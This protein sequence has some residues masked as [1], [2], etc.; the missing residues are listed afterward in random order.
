MPS[1]P[2]TVKGYLFY[3][4]EWNDVSNKMRQTASINI[5]RGADS[6]QG[7]NSPTKAT[8]VMDN[9]DGDFSPRNPE[10]PLYGKIGRNTPMRIAVE[11]GPPYANIPGTGLFQESA[12][13]ALDQ[14]EM[15]FLLDADIRV[16]LSAREWAAYDI[17]AGIALATRWS[18]DAP[19]NLCWFL[20]RHR[21]GHLY[22]AWTENG[23]TIGSGGSHK[24]TVTVPFFNGE[25][26]AIR[27]T[28]DTDNGLGGYTLRFFY[29]NQIDGEWVELGDAI[30]NTS[31]GSTFIHNGSG[32][33]PIWLGNSDAI[34]PDAGDFVEGIQGKLYAF[35]MRQGIDGPLMVDFDAGRDA[36]AGDTSV[37]DATTVVWGLS[38][39]G[40]FSNEYVRISGEVPSWPPGRDLSGNDRYSEIE[41]TGVMRRLDAG[42]KPLESALLRYL[43]TLSPIECWP[44]IDG[45]QSQGGASIVGGQPMNFWER[46]GVNT[47][48]INNG[49]YEWASGTIASWIEPVGIAAEATAGFLLGECRA[50]ATAT[51]AW[52]VDMF[53]TDCNDSTPE[54]EMIDRT[55]PT[56]VDGQVTW[57]LVLRRDTDSMQLLFDTRTESAG[58]TSLLENILSPGIFD[59]RPHHIRLQVDPGAS[60]DYFLYIDGQLVAAGTHGVPSTSLKQLKFNWFLDSEP[61]VGFPYGFITYWGSDYP[62]VD[63]V[64]Q[65]F[66]GFPGDKTGAR[67]DRLMTE[68]GLNP[69]VTTQGGASGEAQFQE[70]MGTQ[71]LKKFLELLQECA[72]TDVGIL[73]E[74]RD[75]GNLYL[76]A[77]STLYSQ[78]PRFTLD[79]S[80]GV[81]SAPFKPLDDDKLTENDVTVT[82]TGGSFS[83]QVLT[84]GR[85]SIQDYPDGVGRY[86]VGKNLSLYQDSQTPDLAYWFL[87]LG[88]Y[89]GL[90]FT[91]V[92]VDLANPRVYEMAHKILNTDVGDI[93][94]ITGLPKEYGPDD[95]DLMVR[96]YS[97]EIGP[98]SWKITFAC[99]PGGTWDV[100]STVL[101]MYE[102]FESSS[103][104]IPWTN[105]GAGPWSRTTTSPHTG[106]TSLESGAIVNNQTSEAI[107]AVPP[108][109]EKIE[110][111]YRTDSQAGDN[112]VVLRDAATVL[113]A[114]GVGG[115]WKVFSTSVA[116]ASTVTFRYAKDAAGSAG[117]DTVWI[118]DVRFR[119]TSPYG[120]N[121]DT[122]GSAVA[123]AI[124]SSATSMLVHTTDADYDVWCTSDV[125]PADFPIDI[126]VEGERM[127]A[128][129]ILPAYSDK[130]SRVT[131][132]AWG[133]ADTGGVWDQAGGVAANF[134]TNGTKALHI[135]TTTNVSRRSFLDAVH[136]DADIYVTIAASAVATGDLLFGGP[137][138]RYTDGDNLYTARVGFQTSGAI[139][140]SLRKRVAAVETQIA[141]VTPGINYGANTGIRVRFQAKGT[142]L[143]V[144]IWLATDLEPIRWNIDTTDASLSG[145]N[146]VGLRSITGTSNTNVNPAIIYDD[147]FAAGPQRFTVVRSQNG[148][149]KAQAAGGDVRLFKSPIAPL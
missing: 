98:T 3:D 51:T 12:I 37:T 117:T 119:I 36:E 70:E 25:R 124:N 10:S 35:Q 106:T 125:Y 136:A 67:F 128:T 75:Q 26:V 135:L 85:M 55:V 123:V 74:M 121:V 24:S 43:R 114:S 80:N 31:S 139:L 57:N 15:D 100:A 14:P 34:M 77:R 52:A 110:F 79:F 109:A 40:S 71:G 141:A 102:N 94:R 38:E 30:V 132:N 6:E 93:I 46:V 39:D 59:K 99:S 20:A 45:V 53:F 81:I 140:L 1:L 122:S 69:F 111:W 143:R 60:S 5:D 131:A 88:T 28:L 92:T 146:F 83:R 107:F 129:A 9:R 144:K 42:N 108:G 104:S 33:A 86:D 134:S 127:S 148:I 82:R 63:D 48:A 54:W 44:L 73:A 120:D 11:A 47:F 27:V 22:F 149:V 126:K 7:A 112:L 78:A 41:P 13:V 96:G 29:S 115:E 90:R 66:L 97:E 8:V 113:T 84:E 133:T 4:D 61:F 101:D 65:A 68:Q 62:V 19:N 18:F 16:E 138:L 137:T 49:K 2:P 32:Q 72:D 64:W 116:G 50:D 58:S 118:D 23:S 95:V 103:P 17:G 89:D 147:Y 142:R 87:N 91:R 56:D 145:G 130:F 105:G 76:R 21:T